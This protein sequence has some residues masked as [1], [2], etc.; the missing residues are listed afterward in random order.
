MREMSSLNKVI[1]SED[2]LYGVVGEASI[3]NIICE[4]IVDESIVIQHKS[5]DVSVLKPVEEYLRKSILNLINTSECL[6]VQGID[7]KL[8]NELKFIELVQ[9]KRG[10]KTIINDSYTLSLVEFEIAQGS[11]LVQLA[12]NIFE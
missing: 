1:Y 11:D 9:L 7:T 5:V 12:L 8:L 10:I 4:D 6:E 2:Y 3:N